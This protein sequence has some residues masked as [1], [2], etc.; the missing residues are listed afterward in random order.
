[1]G[2]C[3]L[4]GV[5]CRRELTSRTGAGLGVHV[6][7]GSQ[8]VE[9]GIGFSRQ[10]NA[11]LSGGSRWRGF[12]SPRRGRACKARASASARRCSLSACAHCDSCLLPSP[13]WVPRREKCARTGSESAGER[14]LGYPYLVSASHPPS[15]EF[16]APVSF[17]LGAGLGVLSA[18]VCTDKGPSSHVSLSSTLKSLTPIPPLY[19]SGK[20]GPEKG[21]QKEA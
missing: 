12:Y 19:E 16:L 14:R 20:R 3:Q 17:K 6:E 5:G 11:L 21:T 9:R 2:L 15:L 8:P 18:L 4:R 7:A 1:M 10:L 13:P